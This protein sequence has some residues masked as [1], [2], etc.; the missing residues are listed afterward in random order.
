MRRNGRGLTKKFNRVMLVLVLTCVTLTGFAHANAQE[1]PSPSPRPSNAQE[2]DNNSRIRQSG[3]ANSGDAVG[4]QVIGV[5]SSGNVSVDATNRSED[6]TAVTGDATASNNAAA[7]VGE[8]VGRND[9]SLSDALAL[10]LSDLFGPAGPDATNAQ[11][12]DNSSTINQ[13]ANAGSGDAVCGQ[14]GGVVASGRASLALSNTSLDSECTTG[15]A[16][17]NN[18]VIVVVGLQPPAAPTSESSG[19]PGATGETGA[20]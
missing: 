8:A 1:E 12:G 10:G 9:V 20:T 14:V 15:D 16:T 17:Q 2:G 5:V 19:P 3:S 13:S 4:G 11:E 7:F 6:V 18:N